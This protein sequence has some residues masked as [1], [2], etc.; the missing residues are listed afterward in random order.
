MKAGNQPPT[1]LEQVG[2]ALRAHRRQHGLSQRAFADKH[3]LSKS[4]VARFEADPS[5][6][7]LAEA[8]RLLTLVGFDL[9]VTGQ[10]GSPVQDWDPTDLLARTRSKGRFPAH[11]AVHGSG[12][13]GPRW[14][15]HHEFTASGECGPQPAWTA[16]GF[17]PPEGTR[18][19]KVPR[20]YG[21]DEGPRWPY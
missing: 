3:G 10:D 18:F 13:V 8:H 19:G 2:L 1:V 4:T 5:S 9:A 21:E 14:W 6:A 20:P 17:I 12:A 15:V 11:R 16:E 7:S